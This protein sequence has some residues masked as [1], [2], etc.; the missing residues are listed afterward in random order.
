MGNFLLSIPDWNI[1]AKRFRIDL[2]Q[3]FNKQILIISW[4]WVLF[5]PRLFMILAMPSL[6]K[7]I[8]GRQL[9]VFLRWS[10]GSLVVLLTIVHSLEKKLLNISVFL[11]KSVIWFSNFHY[12]KLMANLL[13][14]IWKRFQYP[15]VTLRTCSEFY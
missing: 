3:I 14:M 8:I 1:S 2:P 15:L 9:F 13:F 11:L 5:G 7:E 4:P 10:V 6:V 12:D